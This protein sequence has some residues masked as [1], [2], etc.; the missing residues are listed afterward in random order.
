[1]VG[2]ALS[3]DGA[4]LA[5]MSYKGTARIF[6]LATGDVVRTI[7]PRTSGGASWDRHGYHLAFSPD[8]KLLVTNGNKKFESCIYQVATG[9]LSRCIPGHLADV[10]D[11][12]FT[13]DGKRLLTASNDGTIRL[14]EVA[15]GLPIV[16]L[17]STGAP[18]DSVAML[19]DGSYS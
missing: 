2:I 5:T 4:G 17:V 19:P 16:T 18:S 1:V 9:E 3:P 14:W 6:T 15:T 12:V 11:S 10:T 8:G 7:P 13:P